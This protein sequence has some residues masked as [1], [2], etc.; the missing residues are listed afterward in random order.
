MHTL[1]NMYPNYFPKSIEPN[2]NY[3]CINKSLSEE[4]GE[5]FEDPNFRGGLPP[6]SESEIPVSAARLYRRSL[7]DLSVHPRRAGGG[8]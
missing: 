1:K 2:L 6:V 4:I 7:L 5:Q 8:G 3:N